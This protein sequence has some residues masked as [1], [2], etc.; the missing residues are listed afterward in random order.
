MQFKTT[1]ARPIS[2]EQ[3]RKKHNEINKIVKSRIKCD[4]LQY[5]FG[6]CVV[7]KGKGVLKGNI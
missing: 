3:R 2:T 6:I 4:N 7:Q 5:F 1:L